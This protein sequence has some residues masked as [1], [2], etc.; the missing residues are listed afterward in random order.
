MLGEVIREQTGD[1]VSDATLEELE[2]W[3]ASMRAEGL[4]GSTIAR[5]VSA[6]VLRARGLSSLLGVPLLVDARV[7]GVVHVATAARRHSR[8]VTNFPSR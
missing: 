1:D 5:R 8:S 3:L 4:A 2:R 7:V 6:V